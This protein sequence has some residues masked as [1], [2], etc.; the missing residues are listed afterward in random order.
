MGRG[1]ASLPCARGARRG[2]LTPP[3]CGIKERPPSHAFVF[4]VPGLFPN[5]FF[6]NKYH[7]YL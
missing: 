1:L 3:T 4:E 2:L 5:I 7:I 6:D